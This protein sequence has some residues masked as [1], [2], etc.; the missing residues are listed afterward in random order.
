MATSA[1]RAGTGRTLRAWLAVA[2]WTAVIFSLSSEAFG[3]PETEGFFG[4]WLHWLLPGLSGESLAAIHYAIRKGAHL[5]EYAVLALLTYRALGIGG[6][7]T[8]GR[9][10]GITLALALAVA[11][12]DETRQA[13]TPNRGPSPADVALDFCGALLGAALALR[14]RRLGAASRWL[15]AGPDRGEA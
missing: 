12:L 15:P 2:L 7:A 6:V 14:S 10:L 13:F 11:V 5:S 3:A 4:P 8:R 9:Q 1:R